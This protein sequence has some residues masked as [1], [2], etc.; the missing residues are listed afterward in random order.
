MSSG[1]KVKGSLAIVSIVFAFLVEFNSAFANGTICP[2][3]INYGQ[4]VSCSIDTANELDLF[5]FSANAGDV[6]TALIVTTSGNLWPGISLRNSEGNEICSGS[7]PLSAKIAR[8]TIPSTGTY[9]IL[10][11]DSFNGTFTGN[12][13]LTLERLN[14]GSGP[15]IS[16]GQSVSRTLLSGDLDS[17]VFSANGGDKV[18]VRM[19]INSGNLWPG[20]SLYTPAGD[21]LCNNGSY[22]SAEIASCTIPNSGTY[23]LLAYDSFNGTLTASYSLFL[24]LHPETISVPNAPVG[25]SEGTTKNSYSY[26]TGGSSSSFGHPIEYLFDWGDGTNSGWLSVG[27]TV[28]S[29]LW[30]TPGIYLVK[31]QARCSRDPS[32]VSTWSGA[33]EVVINKP[34]PIEV[35]HQRYSLPTDSRLFTIG[36]GNKIFVA[37]GVNG[38]IHGETLTSTDGVSWAPL[39]GWAFTDYIFYDITYAENIFVA[40]GSQGVVIT[41]PDGINW[42]ERTSPALGL[43]GVT[44]GN[45]I[46]VAV[47]TLSTIITSPDG[48]S[49]T[50]R[51]SGVPIPQGKFVTFE[52]IA[53]GNNTFVLVGNICDLNRCE[54]IILTSPDGIN[55]TTEGQ[56]YRELWGITYGN[57]IFVAVGRHTIITSPDGIQWTEESSESTGHMWGVAYANGT[58]VA[59]GEGGIILTSTDGIT[60]ENINSETTAFLIGIAYGN[61]TFVAA[62]DVILQSDPLPAE[63]ETVS[64]PNTPAGPGNCNLGIS[65]TYS[66]GGSSSNLGHAVEYQFDW[67]GDGSDL[68][69][70]G[71][72][73]QSKVWNIAGT[74]DVRSR[75]RCKTDT[76][77]LSPWSNALTV[78]VDNFQFQIHPTEGTYGTEL[79]ITGSGFGTRKGKVLI[80]SNVLKV[81]EWSNEFIQALLSKPLDAGVYHVMIQPSEPEGTPPIIEEDAFV[82]RPAEIHWIEQSSGSAYDQVTITGKFFGTKKGKVYLEYEE[83]GQIVGKSCKVTKWWM[84]PVTNESEIVFVVPK[85]LPE[86]CDVV[87][88]PYSTLVEV[89]EEDGFEVKAPEV[90][91]LNPG[92]GSVGEQITI[93]GNFFGSKKPKVYLGYL[94]KGKPTKKSCP[95]LSW[96]DDEIVFTVPK[97]PLGIYDVIVTNSVGLDT[98]VSGFTVK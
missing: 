84:D 74:Y 70:W 43:S 49:W 10:V 55:W 60:W 80:G 73:T 58:F 37:M 29:H 97:L 89:G 91:S 19:T 76:N 23:T 71:S 86:V 24:G 14:P 18:Y 66:T 17:Y 63:P 44:H 81:L 94:S 35:W 1:T 83:G 16:Y 30:S 68:S 47:G 51:D 96:G 20:I 59:V 42:T 88:D 25:A 3:S 92:S 67:K 98:F 34:R 13:N 61:N 93:A 8:C 52:K 31:V 38:E 22:T 85:M 2:S 9:N 90:E 57:G 45:N 11:K 21:E 82:V 7:G 56:G 27:K 69:S 77:I 54:G 53:Y 78:M 72:D 33:L 36:Y 62:G 50:K 79:T 32:V 64:P 5:T 40:V 95:I 12:Y 75:A 4:T 6:V 39:E 28:D 87:V 65:C 46:F 15:F 26:S 48:R 41:S